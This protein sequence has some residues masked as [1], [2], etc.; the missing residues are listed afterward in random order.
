MRES[1]GN[2]M[3][4]FTQATLN[5]VA[6]FDA[7]VLAQ[8]L[9]YNQ[10]DFWNF[11]WSTIVNFAGGWTANT[12]PVDLVGATIDAQIVRRAITNFSDS[13]TGYDFQINDYPL[14]PLITV[15]TQTSSSGN[16]MTAATTKDMF[17]GQPIRFSGAVFGGVAINTTYYVKTIITDTTFTISATSGGSTF[18]LTNASG[19]MNMNRVQPTPVSLPITNRQ[20]LK[21]TFTMTIDDATWGLIA[22]DPDLDINSTD[23]ACYTGRVKISFPAIGSQPAYDEAVFLLFLVNSDGVVNTGAG[24]A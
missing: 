24:V 20:D 21:G 15:V 6:G 18:V 9:I 1:R 23:P 19:T 22:G 5:Q 14:I 11:S 8:N 4:K 13:R 16:I 12:V 2:I 7:Q 3:A 10:K 17:V